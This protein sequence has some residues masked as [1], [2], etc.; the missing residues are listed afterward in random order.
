MT[1]VFVGCIGVGSEQHIRK[2]TYRMGGNF[3]RE[4]FGGLLVWRAIRQY[5]HLP[6]YLQYDVIN[7]IHIF[8]DIFN[9]WSTIIQNVHKTSNYKRMEQK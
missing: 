6:I 2:N 9:V 7:Y 1:V 5:F 8:C 3:G 4:F